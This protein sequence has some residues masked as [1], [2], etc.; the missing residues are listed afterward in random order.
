VTSNPYE[1]L[2]EFLAPIA[3]GWRGDIGADLHDFRE[4]VGAG[5]FGWYSRGYG[6]GPDRAEYAV[7]RAL[8]E[9][10]WMQA[11]LRDADG[12]FVTLRA[13]QDLRLSE[14]R[15]LMNTIASHIPDQCRFRQYAI[16]EKPGDLQVSVMVLARP[17]D[18]SGSRGEPPTPY[19]GTIRR[20]AEDVMR[21]DCKGG[22]VGKSWS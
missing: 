4:V 6:R 11:R 17:T 12:V 3:S 19:T 5:R 20:E 9:L 8:R 21:L 2:A 7:H 22:L 10:K 14:T 13:G 15:S 1:E 16:D 18:Q